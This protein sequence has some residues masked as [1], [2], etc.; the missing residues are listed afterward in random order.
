[1]SS[2]RASTVTICPVGVTR[3][4]RGT[5]PRLG[6][7]RQPLRRTAPADEPLFVIE[8]ATVGIGAAPAKEPPNRKASLTVVDLPRARRDGD[9]STGVSLGGSS[10]TSTN[11]V[12][13]HRRWPLQRLPVSRSVQDRASGG[14]GHWIRRDGGRS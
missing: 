3:F 8:R 13:M 14:F 12:A 10:G 5:R 2:P 6:D 1:M 4:W 9:R 7:I 11:V